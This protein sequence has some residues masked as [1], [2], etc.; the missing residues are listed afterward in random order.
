[1]Y[2]DTSVLEHYHLLILFS[3]LDNG[4]S[5]ILSTLP[6]I[7]YR[8]LKTIMIDQ[9]LATDMALHFDFITRLLAA[10]SLKPIE[11]HEGSNEAALAKDRHPASHLDRALLFSCILKCADIS[12]ISRDFHIHQDWVCRL[13]EEYTEQASEYTT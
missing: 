10:A 9:I 11:N 7:S 6:P 8:E 5:N 2:H 12:N 1:M 3:I 4:A 13:M